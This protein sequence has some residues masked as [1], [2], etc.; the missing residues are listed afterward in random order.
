M[1]KVSAGVRSK[2]CVQALSNCIRGQNLKVAHVILLMGM[3][4]IFYPFV[5]N[6][7]L[8]SNKI[9]VREAVPCTCK[10]L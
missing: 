1:E 7:E 9:R 5:L 8:G 4:V 2:A 6:L 10:V 3:E